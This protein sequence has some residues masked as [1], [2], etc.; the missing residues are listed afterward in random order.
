MEYLLHMNSA[1][2]INEIR[3]RLSGI[4]LVEYSSL[5]GERHLVEFRCTTCRHYKRNKAQLELLRL[6]AYEY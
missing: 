5:W 2:Y 6:I 1:I 3:F 4:F